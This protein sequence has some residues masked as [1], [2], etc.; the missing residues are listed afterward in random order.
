MYFFAC[1]VLCKLQLLFCVVEQIE[2]LLDGSYQEV[3]ESDDDQ[4]ISRKVRVQ[5]IKPD[6]FLRILYSLFLKFLFLDVCSFQKLLSTSKLCHYKLTLYAEMQISLC[7]SA[8]CLVYASLSCESIK[9]D[10]VSIS[11]PFR[12]DLRTRTI[13]PESR[14]NMETVCN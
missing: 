12:N 10:F 5:N 8:Y 2:K 7:L 4:I 6:D 3:Q 9:L 1:L 14:D 11:V 13:L